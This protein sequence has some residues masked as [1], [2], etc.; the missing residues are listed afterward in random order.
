M[1]PSTRRAINKIRA[2]RAM[3]VSAG[4][5]EAEAANAAAAAARIMAEHQIDEETIAAASYDRDLLP[6]KGVSLH[7]GKSHPF[8]AVCPGVTHI[9]GCRCYLSPKGLYVVGDEVGRE[10]AAYLFDLARNV[11]DAAWE[12]EKRSRQAAF[13]TTWLKVHGSNPPRRMSPEMAREMRP[14]GFSWDATTRRSFGTG[15]A[16]RIAERMEAMP[17]ARP[18]PEDAADKIMAD[19]REHEPKRKSKTKYDGRALVAGAEA[20][21][22]VQ[23]SLGVDRAAAPVLAIESKGAPC[24]GT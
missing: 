23:I 14:L 17:P 13:R 8:V 22:S 20:G 6:I 21:A 15:M 7:Q 1:N 16:M 5:T 9:S 4:A 12:A 19:K 18:C 3:K 2:L 10:I 24:S 11:I